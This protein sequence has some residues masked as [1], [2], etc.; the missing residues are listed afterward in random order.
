[1]LSPTNNGFSSLVMSPVSN[2]GPNGVS[3]GMG[4]TSTSFANGFVFFGEF[5]GPPFN[6]D[7]YC[8]FS[9]E[10]GT[11]NS[12]GTTTAPSPTSVSIGGESTTKP[13]C[14]TASVLNSSGSTTSSSNDWTGSFTF[15]W[16]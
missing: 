5:V 2:I 11:I 12:D 14:K 16:Q 3:T 8:S 1:V 13:I 6:R 10:A 9:L 4:T 15:D 7:I